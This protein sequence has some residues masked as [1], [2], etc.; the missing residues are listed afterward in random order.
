VHLRIFP[1]VDCHHIPVNDSH[2]S[3]RRSA[4]EITVH[5]QKSFRRVD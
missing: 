4:H 3:A 1:R 2:C 5:L